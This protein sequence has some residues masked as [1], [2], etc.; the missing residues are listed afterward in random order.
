MGAAWYAKGI[1]ITRHSLPGWPVV[2]VC[3]MP[4]MSEIETRIATYSLRHGELAYPLETIEDHDLA[5]LRAGA[6]GFFPE[7]VSRART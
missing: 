6:T 5:L 1:R 2:Q 7:D 4:T 3:L